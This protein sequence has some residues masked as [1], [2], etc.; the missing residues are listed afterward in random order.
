M[1]KHMK[2]AL[3]PLL[4]LIML[5]NLLIPVSASFAKDGEIC[6]IM[7]YADEE[8]FESASMALDAL[9]SLAGR[10]IEIIDT[11]EHAFFGFYAR[12]EQ[13]YID[14]IDNSEYFDANI[15]GYFSP[16][17]AD[18]AEYSTSSVYASEML[19]ASSVHKTG[20]TGKGS[21]VAVIDNGF[22]VSH[23]VFAKAP[24]VSALKKE[25]IEKLMSD[26]ELASESAGV[27]ANDVYVSEK[28]PYAFDYTTGKADVSTLEGH[29]TH[30]AAVIGADCN[31]MTG[32]APDCQLLLMKVFSSSADAS[33]YF[34][35][36]ALEDAV[37]LGADVINLSLGTY[38][39]SLTTNKNSVISKMAKRLT[40][41]GITV[42]C[43]A[44]NDSS[45]AYDSTFAEKYDL[46]YPL[47]EMPDYGTVSHPAIVEDFIAV[48]S[49][50][51][52]HVSLDSL[53]HKNERGEITRIEY[54]D[55]NVSLGITKNTFAKH[56]A[57]SVI[58][59]VHINGVGKAEDY[60]D[61][62][63]LTGKIALI[64]RGEIPFMDKVN[65]AA[66]KGAVGVIIYGNNDEKEVYME[67]T[68]CNIPAVYISKQDGEFLLEASPK[69]LVFD[70]SLSDFISN[71][72]AYE[73][74]SF[75]SWGVT[76]ELT[77]KPDITSVGES[78][79]SA[80]PG[81]YASLSGTSMASPF[82][83]GMAALFCEK[84]EAEESKYISSKRPAFI[85]NA[86]MFSS[87]PLI[88]PMS[89]AEYSPR[90]QG[91]GLADIS[92]ALNVPFLITGN[93]GASLKLEK[94]GDRYSLEFEVENLSETEKTIELDISLLYDIYGGLSIEENG[95]KKDYVFN[96]LSSKRIKN[97]SIEPDDNGIAKYSAKK[98]ILC[99]TLGAKK[100]C[101]AKIFIN[102]DKNELNTAAF[103]NGY[104][105][106]GFLY[107]S[108]GE[109]KG[110]V[111]FIGFEGDFNSADIFD[112]T[113]YSGEIPFFSGNA[114][115]S[116]DDND[117]MVTLGNSQDSSSASVAFAPN[118]D[119]NL[120]LLYFA[121]SLLRNISYFRADI[122]DENGAVLY[123]N[124][125]FPLTK[126]GDSR[127]DPILVWDGS[128]GINAD[129]IFPDGNYFLKIKATTADSKTTQLLVIPFK[130]DT[131][132]P[133]LTKTDVFKDGEKTL[134]EISAEDESR[135][136]SITLYNTEGID[137]KSNSGYSQSAE[138]DG[139]NSFTFDITVCKDSVLW[140]DITDFAMNTKTFK[141]VLP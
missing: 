117:N 119:F 11:F 101:S 4:T 63:D 10:N 39:G 58:R 129:Y 87:K 76:P 45:S 22:D 49:A 77:A 54:C 42:V 53:I 90:K 29:G 35:A 74:S 23:E 67:L 108:D 5:I 36:A 91:A 37:A 84:L 115:M 16:L 98:N 59:Y 70:P 9:F 111:P 6:E 82:I 104:F 55:T 48:A 127:H 43:A 41:S 56:F 107:A 28:I 97:V 88:N 102:V 106:E 105:I 85:K 79:Y 135:I 44:G 66:E 62:I 78:V 120:D 96:T 99:I 72:Y 34:V 27:S 109:F 25:D 124:S 133:K 114:L 17:K 100:S 126:G 51:N 92:K 134:I 93:G 73:M 68:S 123:T 131:A 140:A 65:I 18:K 83:S 14:I 8:Y 64:Q 103:T 24:D 21:I 30:V 47:A 20:F 139:D 138:Y 15:C 122:T 80:V 112:K 3:P 46:P 1:K 89:D 95:V 19:G 52:T 128:D 113:I 60:P 75:S 26:G 57:P 12:A 2:R 130:I 71:P 33:E 121:P 31:T 94:A 13:K 69:E 32:V 81:T 132:S 38:S 141:I 40:K 137:T 61:H 110:S 125:G 86:L 118:F 7:I 50:K 136:K 116:P